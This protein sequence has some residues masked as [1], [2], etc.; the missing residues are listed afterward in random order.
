MTT[1]T[2]IQIALFV[3]FTIVFF[4]FSRS[5]LKDPTK[6]GFYR[7]FG[8]ELT[9]FLVVL[10]LRMWFDDPTS[11]R[12]ISSWILLLLSLLVAMIG[13]L[14]L[15]SIGK[16]KGFFENTTKLV[17]SGLYRFIR[18]PL[19]SSLILGTWGAALKNPDV[20]SLVIALAA[21]LCYYL[22]AKV[23]EEEML[24]K[25]GDEY[26]AYMKRTRRFLPFIF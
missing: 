14:Q 7:F 13:F 4:I 21:T 22:T 23:E 6:H 18:H 10:N 11:P 8:W 5:Y 19:Y 24:V 25:F 20:L 17:E 26:R 2:I 9:L 15:S 3:V 1:L 16:P 12:Q